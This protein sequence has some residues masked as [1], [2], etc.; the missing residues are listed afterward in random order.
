[1]TVAAGIRSRE[2]KR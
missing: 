2:K 1:V